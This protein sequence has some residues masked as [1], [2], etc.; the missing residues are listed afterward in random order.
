MGALTKL[1]TLGINALKFAETLQNVLKAVGSVA[2]KIMMLYAA[3]ASF[4]TGKE[5]SLGGDLMGLI[6]G[7]SDFAGYLA[8][9]RKDIGIP[10]WAL[11][12][13]W[14][15]MMGGQAP[16]GTAALLQTMPLAR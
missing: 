15:G 13:T 3:G 5:R 9:P 11:S 4:F 14:P 8:S 16:S 12:G 10:S 6:P 1:G 7:M 2:D